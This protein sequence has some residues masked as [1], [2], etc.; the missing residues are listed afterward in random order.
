MQYYNITKGIK[1][2]FYETFKDIFKE[3]NDKD[4]VIAFVDTENDLK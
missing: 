3:E 4:I 2:V 1:S